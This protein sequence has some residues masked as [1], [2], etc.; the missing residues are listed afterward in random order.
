MFCTDF[1]GSG[2]NADTARAEC[3]QRHATKAAWLAVDRR[4]VGA[5]GIFSAQSCAERNAVREVQRA[6]IELADS[7]DFGTCVFR[8]NQADESLWHV[9]TDVPAGNQGKGG[10]Q[11]ACDLFMPPE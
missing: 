11:R 7:G 6:P 9:L 4:Y 1:S 2:W 5:G 10:M 8:C 3:D